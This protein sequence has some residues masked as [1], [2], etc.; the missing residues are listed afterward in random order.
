VQTPPTHVPLAQL[1]AGP[2]C[3][4]PPQ[5]SICVLEHWVAFGVHTG[6]EAH[7][8]LPHAQAEVH[9]CEP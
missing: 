2:H 7:E 4:Q 5:V 1:V 6:A 9:V 3:P 8:Q